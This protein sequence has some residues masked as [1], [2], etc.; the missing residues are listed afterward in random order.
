MLN[1]E[2][3]RLRII[4]HT[5]ESISLLGNREAM[6]LALG[7]HINTFEIEADYFPH[8]L[9]AI[10]WW[11]EQTQLYPESF[12]WYAPWEIVLQNENISIGG[13]GFAGPPEEYGKVMIGYHIDLRYR[14]MGYMRE[15]LQAMLAYAFRDERVKAVTATIPPTNLASIATAKTCGFVL[16]GKTEDNGMEVLFFEKERNGLVL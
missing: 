14:R 7:L 2:T 11:Q 8:I 12:A 13:I 10:P 5:P 1:I 6:L 16:V 15:A 4:C 9:G 3:P